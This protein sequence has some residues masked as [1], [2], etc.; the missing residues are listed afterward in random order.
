MRRAVYEPIEGLPAAMSSLA[1]IGLSTGATTGSGT[2]SQS[3]VEGQLKLNTAEL[4]SAIQTNPAEVQTMLQSWS[5]SFTE[6]VNVEA[7][8]GGTLQARLE[9][10]STQ[11]SELTSRITTMNEMLAVR[12]KT[13]QQEFAAMEAVMSQNQAQSSFLASQLTSLLAATGGSSSSSSK[14]GSGL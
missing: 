13:L 11:V 9:G 4:E 14:P 7:A 3:A 2:P 8:P 12:Q 1:G 5:K 10:D 6:M